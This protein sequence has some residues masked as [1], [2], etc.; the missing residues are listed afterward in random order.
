[1]ARFVEETLESVFRQDYPHIEFIVM[2]GGSTDGTVDILRRFESRASERISFRWFSGPDGGT[3]DAI[4][5]GLERSQGSIVAYLNADDTYA[6]HAVRLA[7][8]ALDD[9]PSAA[10]VYGE[11][12]WI[13]E[14]GTP[15]GPYPTRDF[16]PARLR[17]ECFICQPACFLRRKTFSDLGPFDASLRYAYDYEYWIRLAGRYRLRRIPQLL[18]NSRMHRDNKT[19]GQRKGVL[20]E[21]IE[22]LKRHDGYA[23]FS[24]VL[25]YSAYLI[26]RR[27]QFFE[28]FQPSIPKYLFS[29]PVG[30][31]FNLRHPLR[32]VAE[33]ARR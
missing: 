3:A 6:P 31:R 13:A 15:I 26:D 5:R 24:H 8:E 33:W 1:M 25:A 12:Q 14:D 20:R 4:N 22:I 17:S 28:P 27:D 7:V 2:D 19:L 18:A 30:L 29:L 16:D 10:G 23:P 9:D 11:A 21:N 32:Y